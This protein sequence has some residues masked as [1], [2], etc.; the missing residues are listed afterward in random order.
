[1]RYDYVVGLVSKTSC[2]RAQMNAMDY[3]HQL[4]RTCIQSWN[5]QLQRSPWRR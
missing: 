4:M 5:Q 3:V 1:M 2:L